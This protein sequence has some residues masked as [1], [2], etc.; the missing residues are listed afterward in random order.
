MKSLPDTTRVRLPSFQDLVAPGKKT[1]EAPSA[2]GEKDDKAAAI[3]R[4]TAGRLEEEIA[5]TRELC[6]SMRR[7]AL[8]EAEQLLEQARQEAAVLK[9]R[10]LKEARREAREE[11]DRELSAIREQ[12]KK[13]ATQLSV[14]QQ[15]IYEALEPHFLDMIIYISECI[16]QYE[17]DRGEKAY[18]A[19]IE[20]A[21]SQFYAGGKDISLHL[22]PAGYEKLVGSNTEQNEFVSSMQKRGITIICDNSISGG[23]CIVTSPIGS[24]R[25]GITAQL[26]RVKYAAAPQR[27]EIGT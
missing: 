25:A 13:I 23:D 8:A 9:E 26:S 6:A 10:A 20:N 5:K 1:P 18:K 16:L 15:E 24:I 11:M 12:M 2:V 17:L 21:L 14:S 22:S 19:I 27:G 4:E 7:E 3:T